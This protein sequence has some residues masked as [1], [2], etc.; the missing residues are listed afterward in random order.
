[1]VEQGG[2]DAPAYVF[3]ELGGD[4]HLALHDAVGL[5]IVDGVGEV[6]GEDG[7]A[8]VGLEGE[9]HGEGVAQQALLGKYAVVGM[10][11]EVAELDGAMR[12]SHRCVSFWMVKNEREPSTL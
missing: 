6:V 8:D 7:L 4:L 2:A 11:G 9:V 1:M 3:E 12:D 10:E 5:G